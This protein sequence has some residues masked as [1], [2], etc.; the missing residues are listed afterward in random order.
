MQPF[1]EPGHRPPRPGGVVFRQLD[2]IDRFDLAV[3]AKAQQGVEQGAQDPV[4]FGL[5]TTEDE[6][7]GHA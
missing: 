6:P 4:V 3:A 1:F 5:S 2:E 7:A